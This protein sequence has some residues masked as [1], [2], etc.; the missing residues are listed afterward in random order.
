MTAIRLATA[1][2]VLAGTGAIAAGCGSDDS[3]SASTGAAAANSSSGGGGGGGYGGGGTS[4][5]PAQT[6]AGAATSTA[7]ARGALKISA[8]ES[9]GLSFDKKSLTAKAGKVT[10]TMDNPSGNSQMHAVAIEGN[11]TDEDGQTAQPGGTS[12]VALTLKPGQ[13]TF[14]CPVP[15]HRQAG[16]EG[17][18]TVQ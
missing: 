1:V 7:S 9:N 12:T 6:T 2:A 13:Y 16:M 8:V 18:L 14:Y 3:S 11:G 15:G 10:I 4:T 17:T 5:P